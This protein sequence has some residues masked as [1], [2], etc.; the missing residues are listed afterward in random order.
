MIAIVNASGHDIDPIDL[1]RLLRD[2]RERPVDVRDYLRPTPEV[3]IV[4]LDTLTPEEEVSLLK[5]IGPT[6]THSA[7]DGEEARRRELLA[8]FIRVAD[9]AEA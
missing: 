1:A 6:Q 2:R 7:G 3:E 5:R 4:N 9:A 8:R